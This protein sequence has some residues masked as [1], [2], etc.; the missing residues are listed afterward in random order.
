MI[1]SFLL[2]IRKKIIQMVPRLMGPPNDNDIDNHE[3]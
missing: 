2:N 1:F 3:S